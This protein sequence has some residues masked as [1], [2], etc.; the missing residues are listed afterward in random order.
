MNT[1]LAQE[2]AHTGDLDV[3]ALREI[4]G[5]LLGRLEDPRGDRRPEAAHQTPQRTS[6]LDVGACM[7]RCWAA[8][9]LQASWARAGAR[10]AWRRGG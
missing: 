5:E 4:L 9:G 2:R 7:A 8:P 10:V 1:R 6:R 3:F